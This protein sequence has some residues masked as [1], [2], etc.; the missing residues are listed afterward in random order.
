MNKMTKQIKEYNNRE[1]YKDDSDNWRKNGF[2]CLHQSFINNKFVATW[3]SGDDMPKQPPEIK[4]TLNEF[5][6]ELASEKNINITQ[7]IEILQLEKAPK[8]WWQ[9]WR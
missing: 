2:R 9:F 8:K 5:L 4:M 6:K 3:V 1:E 7:G